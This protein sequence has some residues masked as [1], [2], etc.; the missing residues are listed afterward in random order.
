MTRSSIA[1]SRSRS[2][3]SRSPPIRDRLARF[4]REAQSA[5]VAQSSAHRRDLRIRRQGRRP[6]SCSSSSKGRRWPTGSRAG[7]SRCAEALAIARQIAQALD[8][9]HEQ[10]I[11]HRDLKPAN[12]KIKDDGTV[13]VLDFGL[14]KALTE[15]A[16]A[17]PMTSRSPQPSRL[18]DDRAGRDS[19]HGRLHV[20][21][22]AQRA[23]RPTNAPTSGRLARALR[24]ARRKAGVR[25][26]GHGGA[27]RRDRRTSSPTGTPCRAPVPPAVVSVL[28]R[29]LQKDRKLRARDIADVQALLDDAL[30]TPA[31]PAGEHAVVKRPRSAVAGWIAAGAVAI[32]AGL[33]V[34]SRGTSTIDAP[35]TRLE[36]HDAASVQSVL[37][38]GVAGWTQNRVCGVRRGPA[39]TLASAVVPRAGPTAVRHRLRCPAVLVAGWP[40]DRVFRRR[41][42]QE[43]RPRERRRSM[44]ASAPQSRA[45]RGIARASSCS[46]RDRPGRSFVSLQTAA[47]PFPGHDAPARPDQSPVPA[48]AARRPAVSV[49]DARPRGRP[50]RVSCV[51]RRRHAAPRHGARRRLCVVAARARSWS[52]DRASCGPAG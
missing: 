17:T 9:A 13:K 20:P 8:T 5:R 42:A 23:S 36:N 46:A 10:G 11:V 40:V 29:C 44:L 27:A 38:C 32:A 25:R 22:Q 51:A 6:R 16:V 33:F 43:T 3:R 34:I 1:K 47:A 39:T 49:H 30:A 35:E 52:P 45:A 31:A 26:S 18:R 19:R 4:Q 50:R 37:D 48:P 41:A 14:A 15:D 12:I 2:C 24:D 21:E 7:P 28:K